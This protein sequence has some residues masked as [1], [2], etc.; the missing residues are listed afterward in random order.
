MPFIPRLG[1]YRMHWISWLQ[2]KKL[3]PHF[4]IITTTVYFEPAVLHSEVL[5]FAEGNGESQELGQLGPPLGYCQLRADLK[6]MP[7]WM[8]PG[9]SGSRSGKSEKLEKPFPANL[10]FYGRTRAPTDMVGVVLTDQAWPKD[11]AGAIKNPEFRIQTELDPENRFSRFALLWLN[12]GT[13]RH[14]QG[15]CRLG[16]T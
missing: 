11:H 5:H 12:R 15:T 9:N 10:P 16:L 13:Y 4:L 2:W 1:C 6:I 7:G 3:Y 14:L 8:D